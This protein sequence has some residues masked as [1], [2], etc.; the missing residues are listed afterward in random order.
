MKSARNPGRVSVL[1]GA[2]PAPQRDYD[3]VVLGHGSGGRLS[4]EL[5][6][7]VILA[8]FS[9]HAVQ[10]LQDQASVEFP[11]GRLAL[12]TDSFVVSPLFFPGGNI[13]D[14]AINGTVNDLA[15]GGARPLYI[16]VALILEEGL[17]I[18]T[19]RQILG[20]MARAAT[21]AGVALV[22]GDTKVVERGRADGMYVTTTGVGVLET[23]R[24][25][26]AELAC[27]GDRVLVSGTLGDHGISVLSRREGFDLTTDLVSDTAALAPLVEA[28]LTAAPATHA[29]RDPT[30]GGVSSA[31]NE[32]AQ[33][34]QV[35]MVLDEARLPIHP[36]VRGACELLGFDPL[37]VANEGKLVAIVP[38]EQAEAALSALRAHAL[39]RCATD[40]GEVC[41]GTPGVSIR[42]LVGGQ[43]DVPMLAGEQLPRIC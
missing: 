28:L 10:H 27:P 29:L 19:L 22:T 21:A 13:G 6:T 24:R 4:Q 2:C 17:E 26:G 12:T 5:L 25:L 39:G 3:R 36:A 41:A 1:N 20:T 40:I 30:R 15:M 42:S 32:I 38:A 14:L 33:A 8:E 7:R 43:R 31:L 37:Y 16:S 23:S 35:H 18:A 11:T 9:Q 34:S